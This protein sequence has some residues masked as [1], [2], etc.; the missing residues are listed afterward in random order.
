MKKN[1]LLLIA[2][3]LFFAC[4]NDNESSVKKFNVEKLRAEFITE[5]VTPTLSNFKESIAN[6]DVEIQKFTSTPSKSN[7]QKL[8]ESWRLSTKAFSRVQMLNI[9]EVKTSLIMTSFYT[10]QANESAIEDLLSSTK[11]ITSTTL[12]TY[13]TNQ[14]GFAAIEYLIFDKNIS[15]TVKGFSNQ[16]QKK[17][18]LALGKNLIEKTNIL[19]TQW[20]SYKSNFISNNSTGINGGLNM[21]VNEINALLENVRRFKI[22]EPAGLE[23]TTIA[24]ATLLQAKKSAYSLVL[25]AENLK[26]IEQVYF[27][28]ENSIDNYITFITKSEKINAKVKERFLAIQKV[29]NTL[30]NTP[31]KDAVLTKPI[32]VKKLYEEVRALIVLIKADVASALSLTITF[33]DNDGD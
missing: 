26:I 11:S 18:L 13:S 2:L 6:L 20:S 15:E 1:V 10:W 29:L 12:N 21:V 3:S 22:G 16:R 9:G 17:Y 33:T 30:S 8:Q 28:T 24:D 32:Q 19:T 4:G 14:R 25:I 27:K 7:L 5:V 31:L 23:R